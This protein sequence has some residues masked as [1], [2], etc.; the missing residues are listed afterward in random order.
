VTYLLQSHNLSASEADKIPA[1][2]PNGRLLKGDV[3]A[4]VGVVSLTYPKS[5]SNNIVSRQHLDLSNIKLSTPLTPTPAP[6]KDTAQTVTPLPLQE[7]K[8]GIS[9]NLFEVIE[10]QQRIER[11]LGIYM[12]L[13]TFIA[14]AT[15][16][17]NGDFPVSR[18]VRLTQGDLFNQ[19]LGL[20]ALMPRTARGSFT[21]QVSALPAPS[22]TTTPKPSKE[23][24]GMGDIIDV[25]IGTATV[26]TAP[27]STHAPRSMDQV[28][29]PSSANTATT[30]LI[31]AT[32]PTG[33]ER[34]GRLFLE[35]VKAYLESEPG[36]LVL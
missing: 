23:T 13:S 17:A 20:N 33:D 19:I 29:V 7:S 24:T 8:I 32:V 25:L 6:I 34:R 2:G 1:T 26:R 16:I 12:P 3:L 18:N 35:R 14:H 27:S 31:S 10:V 5:L 30:N 21:P 28:V 22:S 36:R 9:V 4:Y 11:K 15:D